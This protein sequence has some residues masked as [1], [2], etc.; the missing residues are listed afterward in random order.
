MKLDKKV[1]VI[2]GGNSG[3]GLGIAE[4]FKAEGASGVISAQK[5]SMARSMFWWSIQVL[6]P[7]HLSTTW[8]RLS[9]TVW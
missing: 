4:E 9:L 7:L 3:I 1:A 6:R 2:T 5:R 8:T